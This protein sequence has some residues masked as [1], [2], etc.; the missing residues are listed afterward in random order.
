[1]ILVKPVEVFNNCWKVG[2]VKK[3]R[4]GYCYIVRPNKWFATEQECEE[5]ILKMAKKYEWKY[6]RKKS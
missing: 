6:E 5:Y 1:M 2:T 3:D 4:Y